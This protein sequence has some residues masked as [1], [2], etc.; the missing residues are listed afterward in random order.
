[1]ILKMSK[2]YIDTRQS[3]FAYGKKDCKV[4]IYAA[5]QILLPVKRFLFLTTNENFSFN[6]RNDARTVLLKAEKVKSLEV[7][8]EAQDIKENE[9]I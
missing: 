3:Q 9:G 1:M 5:E 8:E 6:F 2:H 4:N 7:V